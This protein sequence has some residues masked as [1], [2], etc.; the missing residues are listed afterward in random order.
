MDI[1][2]LFTAGVFLRNLTEVAMYDGIGMSRDP[3][4]D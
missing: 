4:G 3:A 1:T 2:E